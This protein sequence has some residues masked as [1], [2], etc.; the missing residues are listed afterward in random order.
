M[1][2]EGGG[3]GFGGGGGGGGVN[4][5]GAR[6]SV[7]LRDPNARTLCETAMPLRDRNVER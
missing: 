6:G 4:W 2:G 7:H 3:G 5:P 1:W